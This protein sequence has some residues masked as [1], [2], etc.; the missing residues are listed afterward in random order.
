[1]ILYYK[2][3]APRKATTKNKNLRFMPPVRQYQHRL[4]K[5]PAKLTLLAMQRACP[6]W[7][8]L[9]PC[10]SIAINEL[11]KLSAFLTSKKI[12]DDETNIE[13]GDGGWVREGGVNT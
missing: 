2:T 4:N 11:S 10:S 13:S 3:K 1:M 9:P 5:N 6:S 8:K 7:P 12:V